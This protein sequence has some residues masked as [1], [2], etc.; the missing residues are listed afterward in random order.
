M[1]LFD[2]LGAGVPGGNI[3]K[4]LMIALAALLASRAMGKGGLASALGGA[5][6]GQPTGRPGTSPAQPAFDGGLIGGL[7]G[8]LD[9]FR[10][11]GLGGLV[12]SWV[13]PGE[14]QPVS[15]QEVHQAIGPDIIDQLSQR[16]GIPRD[17]LL[18]ELSRVLPNLVD[19][20][21]PSGRVPTNA[22]LAQ[23]MQMR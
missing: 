11:K 14:N 12:G 7:G 15:P 8:L 21:T 18:T 9:Q 1:G 5:P 3:S 19:R 16:S 13:G 6:P 17:Q 4:P 2:E 10:Q 22:E 20:L 23:N